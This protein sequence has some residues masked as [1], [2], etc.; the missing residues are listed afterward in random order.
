MVHRSSNGH[1]RGSTIECAGRSFLEAR[2]DSLRIASCARSVGCVDHGH[3]SCGRTRTEDPMMRWLELSL[4]CGVAA[5]T[6][7][8]TQEI[9]PPDQSNCGLHCQSSEDS[10]T[11][12]Q[13]D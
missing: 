4:C 12:D 11:V 13:G 2:H 6:N 10:S 7:N 5:C 8:S 1:R 3:A 9:P